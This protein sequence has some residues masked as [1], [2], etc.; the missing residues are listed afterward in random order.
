MVAVR[1]L[2]D[3]GLPV[4]QPK[5]V[6][7]E[8]NCYSL[9]TGAN[10]NRQI[11]IKELPYSNEIQIKPVDPVD[12]K[13]REQIEDIERKVILQQRELEVQASKIIE[14]QEEMNMLRYEMKM[15]KESGKHYKKIDENEGQLVSNAMDR[16]SDLQ[17]SKRV[18]YKGD[19]IS[20]EVY[21]SIE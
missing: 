18:K 12:K 6:P 15:I 11:R 21:R 16:L 7:F 13:R 4:P 19:K 10:M 14:Q 2:S 8:G 20:Q 3:I 17:I 9:I 5:Y 1:T